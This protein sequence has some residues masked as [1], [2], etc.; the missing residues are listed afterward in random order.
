MVFHGGPADLLKSF[1]SLPIISEQLQEGWRGKL[2]RKL[3]EFQ[4]RY[5][6]NGRESGSDVEKAFKLW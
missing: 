6:L 2:K 4:L 5:L 3:K 1:R